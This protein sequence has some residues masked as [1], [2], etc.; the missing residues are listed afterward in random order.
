VETAERVANLS[1]ASEQSL[2]HPAP[3]RF[4]D[5]PPKERV[6]ATW[7]AYAQNHHLSQWLVDLGRT[8]YG[9]R[10]TPRPE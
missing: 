7:V 4:F 8:Q 9:D 6:A 2:L 1:E 5:Y 3:L 10:N